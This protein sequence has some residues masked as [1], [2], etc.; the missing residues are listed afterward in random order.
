MFLL[1]TMSEA[2]PITPAS[3][4]RLAS[5]SWV[6]VELVG[7]YFHQRPFEPHPRGIDRLLIRHHQ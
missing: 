2:A 6:D 1:E 4:P 7:R 3:F 5:T